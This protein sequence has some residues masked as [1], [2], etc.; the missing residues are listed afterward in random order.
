MEATLKLL[1]LVPFDVVMIV[2]CALLFLCFWR[3]MEKHFFTPYLN[4]LEARETATLGAEESAISG[5]KQAE[6]LKSEYENKIMQVRVAAI[7]KKLSTLDLAKKQAATILE[8]AEG[9][10]QEQVRNVRWDLA[11]K[12]TQLRQQAQSQVGSMADLICSKA[13]KPASTVRQNVK[14]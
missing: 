1:D 13:K 3:V 4:L 12:M 14:Q 10:A 6:I 7:E 8:D 5:M 2:V 9:E 11:N